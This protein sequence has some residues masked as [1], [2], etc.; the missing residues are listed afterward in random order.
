V[1]PNG[2]NLVSLKDAATYITRLPKKE[3]A[4]PEWQTAIEVLM[5]CSRGGDPMMAK[6]GF[7]KALHRDVEREFKSDRKETRRGKRKLKRGQ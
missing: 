4:L 3:S 1:L 6:I 5:L 7:M 2:Q